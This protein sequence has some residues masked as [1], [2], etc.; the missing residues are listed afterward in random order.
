MR[1]KHT[2]RPEEECIQLHRLGGRP[3]AAMRDLK[4]RPF[5]LG[6]GG[7]TLELV[8][9]QGSTGAQPASVF[10]LALLPDSL[11]LNP[12]SH[13]NTAARRLAVFDFLLRAYVAA[14]R[15]H[16]R[17]NRGDEGSGAFQV[18]DLPQQVLER[19]VWQ[20]EPDGRLASL[21]R[22]SLPGRR[23]AALIARE[24]ELMLAE[25]PPAVLAAVARAVHQ[26]NALEEHIAAVE[27]PEAIAGLLQ[28]RGLVAFVLDAARQPR[29]SGATDLPAQG[30]VVPFQA[31]ESLRIVLQLPGGRAVRGG[32]IEPFIAGPPTGRSTDRFT[33]ENASGSTSQAGGLVEAIWAGARLLLLDEDTSA[34]NFLVRDPL[35]DRFVCGDPITPL[36]VHA[37]SLFEELGVSTVLVSGSN[38][39]FLGIADC[40]LQMRRW[41]PVDGTADARRLPLSLP[42]RP[43]QAL[44]AVDPRRL[45][46]HNFCPDFH[47]TKRNKLVPER[48]KPLQAWRVLEYGD[49]QLDLQAQAALVDPVQVLC[50]GRAL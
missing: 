2:F 9:V 16:C 34:T 33:T 37:P 38:S 50:I 22:L 32:N 10:R 7:Q 31:P 40:I 42:A 6:A 18:P 44:C 17:P 27:D 29:R 5:Q 49:D 43:P 47:D 28:Q 23:P 14:V 30:G 25:E 26:R 11:G 21:V 46:P 12:G 48:I 41:L 8:H 39:Q 20:L 4:G 36:L 24:A 19:N 45:A 15:E 1:T 13:L 35:V 3:Y